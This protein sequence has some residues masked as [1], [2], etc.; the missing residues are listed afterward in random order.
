MID[1]TYDSFQPFHIATS[2]CLKFSREGLFFH[3]AKTSTICKASI[4]FDKGERVLNMCRVLK[5]KL[6]NNK[7]LLV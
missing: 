4:N 6:C 1:V 7:V 5:A 2:T 3:V